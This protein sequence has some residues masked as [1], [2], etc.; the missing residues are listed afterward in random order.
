MAHS[1][2]PS[3]SSSKTARSSPIRALLWRWRWVGVAI[4]AV[5]AIQ[6]LAPVS[7]EAPS[8]PVVVTTRDVASG[9]L[10]E[11]GDLAVRYISDE[12]PGAVASVD[13]ATGEYLVGPLVEGAPVLASHLLTSEFLE[14]SPEGTVIAPLAI[15]DAGGITLMQPGVEV[16]L[17]AMPDEFSDATDAQLLVKGV[18]VAGIATDKGAS[19]LLATTEDTHVF[20][21]E[22]PEASI[23]RVLGAGS[24]APLHAVLSGP[25]TGD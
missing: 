21:L 3:P 13:D 24:R 10:L 20:Y 11:S 7:A 1:H 9:E 6:A 17:Y 16:N 12:I 2:R 25:R 19:G 23:E 18:R 14:N 5:L 4:F 22:I 8:V 15:V